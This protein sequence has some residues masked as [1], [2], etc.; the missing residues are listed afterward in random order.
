M[1]ILDDLPQNRPNFEEK[2]VSRPSVARWR[3]FFRYL[4]GIFLTASLVFGADYLLR[5]DRNPLFPTAKPIEL[6]ASASCE[7][8]GA[9]LSTGW[10][11]NNTEALYYLDSQSGRL[12]AGLL[13]RNDPEFLKTYSRNIKADLQQAV[14]ELKSV[15]FPQNPTFIMVTGDGDVRNIGAAEMNSLSKSFIYVAEVNTGIVLVYILPTEGD[16]DLE[17]ENGEIV[18]WTFARLNAG[19]GSRAPVDPNDYQRGKPASKS[20]SYIS[21]K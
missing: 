6:L 8:Q 14:S 19:T 12:S 11:N 18:Y 16:R 15:P 2:A 1:T 3:E 17:V 13:S 5:T 10:F 7:S 4:A 9:V 20:A 21:T